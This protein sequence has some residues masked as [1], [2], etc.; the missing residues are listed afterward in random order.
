MNRT[1]LLALCLLLAAALPAAAEEE[2]PKVGVVEHLGRTLP[3]DTELYDENGNTVTLGSMIDRPTILM[4]VYYKC[5][6]ICTP[7]LTETAGVVDKLGMEPGKDYRILTVSFDTEETPELAR[8]KKET[9]LGQVDRPVDPAGWRFL[10]GEPEAVQKLTDA[11][12]FYFMKEQGQWVHSGALIAV[13][14]SGK[15][16]RY[17]VGI[18]HLPF[19]VRMALYEAAEGRTG[20][21]IAKVMKFCFSY[22]PEGKRYAFDIVRVGGLLVVGLAGVFAAVF[23]FRPKGKSRA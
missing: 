8:D 7:L 19:D 3:L 14:P 21:T 4:F 22:D 16:T 18:R 2:K 9:Y 5:P 1:M 6:G 12:G 13:S 20:P 11:A 15:I 17:L 10:T 23:L